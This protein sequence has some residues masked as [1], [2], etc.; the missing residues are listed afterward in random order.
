MKTFLSI[1]IFC[2]VLFLYIHI[3]FHL[4][5]SDDLEIYEIDSP[6]KISLEDICDLR[7]PIL[8]PMHNEQ[9]QNSCSQNKILD[10]YGAFDIKMRNT[11]DTTHNTTE[12][13]CTDLYTPIQLHS[14]LRVLDGDKSKKFISENNSEFLAETG[15]AK[16]YRI[17]DL[18][19]RPYMVCKTMYDIIFG[20]QHA[21]TPLRYNI[22]YRN[23][24]Y[25][26]EGAAKVK[27]IPPRSSKYLLLHKDYYHFEFRSPINPWNVQP[28]YKNEYSK[29][30]SLEVSLQKGDVLFV[31]SYWWYS[32]QFESNKTTV[33]SMKYRTYMNVVATLPY[34]A[35]HFLQRQNTKL[36]IPK[37]L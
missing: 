10:K 6:S 20:S 9:L 30:Q 27:L 29:V 5:T 32:I 2:I 7:Q 28:E 11:H 23:F 17:N 16:T 37:S 24:F 26:T 15:L 35:M 22:N 33:L 34:Y 13:S 36:E 21:Y 12:L 19:L 18:L 3:H 4:K 31:P 1:F 8:F 14:G 25:V